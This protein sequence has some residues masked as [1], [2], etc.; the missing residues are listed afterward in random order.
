MNDVHSMGVAS[1]V[2]WGG[3]KKAV[4]IRSIFSV[5]I[6]RGERF[7]VGRQRVLQG[8]KLSVAPAGIG[9]AREGGWAEGREDG[10]GPGVLTKE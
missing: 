6:I 9:T 10:G 2:V 8:N 4:G 5:R 1:S 3:V 7:F